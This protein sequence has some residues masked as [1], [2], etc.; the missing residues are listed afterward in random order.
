VKI[1]KLLAPLNDRTNKAPQHQL[2]ANNLISKRCRGGQDPLG[3]LDFPPID[4]YVVRVDGV[5]RIPSASGADRNS[6]VKENDTAYKGATVTSDGAH[7]GNK[8]DNI[9]AHA[10]S[11]LVR[12]KLRAN[13]AG[14]FLDTSR[15]TSA[16]ELWKSLWKRYVA[17]RS[18]D[19]LPALVATWTQHVLPETIFH[20]SNGRER[21]IF[22]KRDEGEKGSKK[23][24]IRASVHV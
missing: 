15:D 17:V 6:A 14:F 10:A 13:F 16:H 19:T 9:N 11:F 2:A 22:R 18:S 12:K 8:G 23:R 1:Q 21:I 20:V 5:S 24:I 4:V 7:C 3:D